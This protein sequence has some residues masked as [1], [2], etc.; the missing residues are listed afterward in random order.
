[1][2]LD[3]EKNRK[4]T[5][6]TVADYAGVSRGTVDRVI[7]NRAH[8]SE[9]IQRR[10]MEALEATGYIST[11]E[12]LGQ[13]I[14][15]RKTE[16]V[17]IGVLLPNWTGYFESEVNRG[18]QKA[19][20]EF[21]AKGLTLLVEKCE[22]DLP[23][24]AILRLG[25]MRERGAGG[26]AVCAAD[27][28][29]LSQEIRGLTEE[30]LPV[31]TFNSD[32]PDSGRQLFVGQDYYRSGR[33]AGELAR[34]CTDSGACVLATAGNRTF[35]SHKSRLQGFLDQMKENGRGSNLHVMETFNDYHLTMQ[36]IGDFL[37][38]HPETKVVYMANQSIAGCVQAVQD[39]GLAARP[40]ILTHD[41]SLETKILL[42][43]GSIDFTISQNIY[44]QGFLPVAMLMD[45]LQGGELP[46]EDIISPEL[47]IICSQ[48]L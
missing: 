39:A 37:K 20:E 9:T 32:L 29:A 34:I 14:S 45:C 3:M 24:E 47:S 44:Q 46:D 48:N 10:V 31:I 33:V 6:Q 25:R 26:F 18:L 27:T 35:F 1:M 19:K 8:V 4:V 12:V 40:V 30:G 43:E 22:S 23:Q 41:Y 38:K 11:K 17:M 16:R 28:P 13:T 42:E 36:K 15:D 5:L 2:D 7:N 21:S